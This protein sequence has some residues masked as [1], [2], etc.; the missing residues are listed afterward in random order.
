M[1]NTSVTQND[2]LTHDIHE[3]LKNAEFKASRSR[4]FNSIL[5]VTSSITAATSTLIAGITAANGPVIGEGTSGWV[6][7]C[8]IAAV[9][10]FVTTVCIGVNQGFGFAER[11]SRTNECAGRLK[12]LEVSIKTGRANWNDVASEYEQIIREFTEEIRAN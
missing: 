12:S 5:L 4:K 9:F 2:A 3:S 10:G 1:G 11:L 6:I 8:I 7:S